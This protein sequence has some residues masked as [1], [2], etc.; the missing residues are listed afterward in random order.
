[1]PGIGHI[2]VSLGSIAAYILTGHTALIT[3]GATGIGFALAEQFQAASN[4]LCTLPPSRLFGLPTRPYLRNSN[5]MREK[6]IVY[7]HKI[8]SIRRCVLAEEATRNM[9]P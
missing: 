2:N 8:P 9:V 1:M 5:N 7:G 4:R 6:P 3:S